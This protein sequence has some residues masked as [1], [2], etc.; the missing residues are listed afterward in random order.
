MPVPGR[1]LLHED[2][3]EVELDGG[4]VE[5]RA[6]VEGDALAQREAERL[7]AVGARLGGPRRREGRLDLAAGAVGQEALVDP[8]V[9]EELVGPV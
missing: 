1:E 5:G 7:A 4:A 2:V 3:V 8:V 6:V 9:R